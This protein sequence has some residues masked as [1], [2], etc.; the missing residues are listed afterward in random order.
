MG[1]SYDLRE[2][3][4]GDLNY[5]WSII[6][7]SYFQFFPTVAFTEFD[8]Q[9]SESEKRSWMLQILAKEGWTPLPFPE[10][11][12]YEEPQLQNLLSILRNEADPHCKFPAK[13]F[14]MLPFTEFPEGQP[15]YSLPAGNNIPRVVRYIWI[16]IDKVS[17]MK[18]K[19][20]ER[21]VKN[22]TWDGFTIYKRNL[23]IPAT[24]DEM[25]KYHSWKKKPRGFGDGVPRRVR[26]S[27]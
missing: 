16:D 12:I 11:N 9:K 24:E 20:F 21:A 2:Q 8:P 25:P 3:C 27:L 10:E 17:D 7:G 15:R 14:V 6:R 5:L 4:F 26:F 19:E 23:A 18:I 22:A 13:M 1:T